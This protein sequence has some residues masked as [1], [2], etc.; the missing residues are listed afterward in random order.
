MKYAQI[1]WTLVICSLYMVVG[2]S[3]VVLNR[4]I[5]KEGGFPYPMLLSSLGLC[6]SALTAHTLAALGAITVGKQDVVTRRFWL[7]RVVPVG[8]CHAATLAFGNAQYLHMGVA[9]VQFLKAFTPIVVT[10][11]AAVLLNDRPTRRLVVSLVVLCAGTAVTAADDVAVTAFGLF[12]AAGSASTEAVR[13]VLTQF[14]LQ[15]C[16]FTLWE[17]QYYLAP[18]AAVSLVL[19]G[20]CYE[21]A[22]LRES[23]D[24]AKVAENPLVF[25]L[26]ASLGLGV[27]LLTAAVIQGPGA[28]TLKVLSQARNAGLVL[29][30]VAFYNETVTGLQSFG[31]VISLLA[32]GA[33]NALK[34][35]ESKGHSSEKGNSSGSGGVGGGS[36][37]SSGSSSGNS[38]GNSSGG[39]EAVGTRISETS[40]ESKGVNGGLLAGSGKKKVDVDDSA[41]EAEIAAIAGVG[42]AGVGVGGGVGGILRS[43]NQKIR[44]T[45]SGGNRKPQ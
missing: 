24:L 20:W 21:G 36:N 5:L 39:R 8:A 40:V 9:L 43:G 29:F 34:M 42:G 45:L 32:F 18:A 26:A 38:S 7:N 4:H 31:Y 30:G 12:L 11:V 33:Y 10:A 35:T 37:N 25:F 1:A 2:P 41:R 6:F 28:V 16:R 3:L 44:S 27:Q 22:R 15:D 19:T 14:V 17:S 23:G 13:L